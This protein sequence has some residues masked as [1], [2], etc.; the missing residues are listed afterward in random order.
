MAYAT[1]TSAGAGRSFGFGAFVA[2]I[3][4]AIATRLAYRRTFTQLSRLNDRELADIGLV[5]CDID[6]VCTGRDMR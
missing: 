2:Y 6:K 5:R 4:E 3:R 1:P